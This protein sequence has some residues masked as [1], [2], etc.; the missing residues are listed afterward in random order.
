MFNLQQRIAGWQLVTQG[1]LDVAYN[2]MRDRDEDIDMLRQRV[3]TLES[4]LEK[5]KFRGKEAKA[6]ADSIAN[7]LYPAKK[8]Q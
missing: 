5:E 6:L 2:A 1:V 7:D 8:R 3:E 4:D